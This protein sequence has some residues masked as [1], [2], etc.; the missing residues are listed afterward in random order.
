MIGRIKGYFNT[1]G[2]AGKAVIAISALIVA[3]FL[4][5]AFRR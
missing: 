1:F 3:G 5:M 2:T 4:I